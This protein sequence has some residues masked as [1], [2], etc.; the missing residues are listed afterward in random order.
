MIRADADVA[1]IGS[2]FAGSL[3]AL[4]LTRMGLRVILLDKTRHPR[5]AIGESSTPAA[6]LVL[7]SLCDRYDLPLLKPLCKYGTWQRECPQFA[8]GLKR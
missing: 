2:G 3:T 1:V 6:D 5:F 8:C 7:A 4:I